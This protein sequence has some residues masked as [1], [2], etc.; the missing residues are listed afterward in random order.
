[1]VGSEEGGA[2]HL[3]A[4][5]REARVGPH[6]D[7]GALGSPWRA[8]HP[9]SASPCLLSRFLGALGS[10][11]PHQPPASATGRPACDSRAG[12]PC[13]GLPDTSPTQTQADTQGDGRGRDFIDAVHSELRAVKCGCGVPPTAPPHPEDPAQ[14]PPAAGPRLDSHLLLAL[15]SD[16]RWARAAGLAALERLQAPARQRGLEAGPTLL[17]ALGSWKKARLVL[18]ESKLLGESEVLPT[19]PAIQGT[20]GAPCPPSGRESHSSRAATGN[21]TG[22]QRAASEG[23]RRPSPADGCC[24]GNLPKA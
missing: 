17:L 6:G 15:G 23:H 21:T 14:G 3:Q 19:C 9:V 1:M 20:P 24:P 7:R 8:C 18:A 10:P 4:L 2:A 22:S 16:R 11:S 12:P 5:W 13:P